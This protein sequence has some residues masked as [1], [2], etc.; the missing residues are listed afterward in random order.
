MSVIDLGDQMRAGMRRLAS[1]VSVVTTRDSNGKA[2]A[3]TASS[4]T[5]LSPEPASLLVCVN[6][7]AGLAG[8]IEKNSAFVVNILSRQQQDISNR[9]AGGDGE[10]RFEVGDW[11]DNAATVPRLKGCEASFNCIADQIIDY[12]THSIV[13][14]QIQ[15]VDVS[16]EES[17]PLIY[18]NGS[19]L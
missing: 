15:S 10:G 13:I 12:G 5:S 6:K 9:C 2:F 19:Y 14:G 4:I 1:G 11:I 17:D 18:C 16:D 7:S 8:V 3:M